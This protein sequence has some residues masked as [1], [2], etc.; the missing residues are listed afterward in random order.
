MQIFE[1]KCIFDWLQSWLKNSC[2][3]M[4]KCYLLI[5]LENLVNYETEIVVSEKGVGSNLQCLLKDLCNRY[6]LKLKNKRGKSLI[7]NFKNFIFCKRGLVSLLWA[8]F[9]QFLATLTMKIVFTF[10]CS[11][12]IVSRGVPFHVIIVFSEKLNNKII[13]FYDRGVASFQQDLPSF[14]QHFI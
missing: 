14:C 13:K 9:N 3:K 7:F 11:T 4:V 10:E 12:S 5:N 2:I 8:L 1:G 6:L